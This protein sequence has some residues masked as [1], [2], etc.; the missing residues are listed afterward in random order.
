M[1]KR[2]RLHIALDAVLDRV[3]I[4]D[5]PDFYHAAHTSTVPSIKSK[6]LQPGKASNWIRRGNGRRYGAGEVNAFE[7]KHDAERWAAKMDWEFN[8]GTGTGKVSIVRFDPGDQVWRVDKTSDPLTQLNYSGRW[9]K[10]SVK[11][12]AKNIK[13]AYPLNSE[14]VKALIRK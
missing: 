4:R 6:G 3:R 14:H 13:E 11:V 7:N 5:M 9:L 12:P 10:S 8:K 1:G 2:E